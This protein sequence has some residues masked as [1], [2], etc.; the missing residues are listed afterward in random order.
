MKT[1]NEFINESIRDAMVPKSDDFIKSAILKQ[2][3]LNKDITNMFSKYGIDIKKYTPII[4]TYNKLNLLSSKI[5]WDRIKHLSEKEIK[6]IKEEIHKILSNFPINDKISLLKS[7]NLYI[8]EYLS[9]D[10]IDSYLSK[11][12]FKKKMEKI[13]K[14]CL[15]SEK[16][17]SKDNLIEY[18]NNENNFDDIL[19]VTVLYYLNLSMEEKRKIFDIVDYPDQLYFPILNK[20]GLDFIKTH[21][22]DV[23]NYMPN[24]MNYFRN[25]IF[26]EFKAKT[27]DIKTFKD[28]QNLIFELGDKAGDVGYRDETLKELIKKQ[29]LKEIKKIIIDLIKNEKINN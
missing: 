7:N 2:L 4:N 14:D 10:E 15:Y 11:L 27:K 12:S 26:D 28:F 20:F 24:H 23:L 16:H 29:D 13:E 1:F 17:I 6:S 25:D 22:D 18:I 19:M 3:S 9:K 5:R 8:E 21:I